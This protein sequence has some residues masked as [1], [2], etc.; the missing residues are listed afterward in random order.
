MVVCGTFQMHLNMAQLKL[1]PIAECDGLTG[2]CE[3]LAEKGEQQDDC[4][5][6]AHEV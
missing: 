4:E 5:Q 3:G 2:H 1:S 6:S